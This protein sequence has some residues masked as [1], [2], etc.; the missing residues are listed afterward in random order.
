MLKTKSILLTRH[1]FKRWAE[2]VIETEDINQA[3]SMSEEVVN[4]I[5][6]V[7]YKRRGEM[8]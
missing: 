3:R 7:I 1:F 8:R 4:Q 6:K 2:R 5:E